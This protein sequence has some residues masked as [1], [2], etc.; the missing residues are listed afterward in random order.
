MPDVPDHVKHRRDDRAAGGLA[1]SSAVKV[2]RKLAAEHRAAIV[3]A[4]GRL[5]REQGF[6]GAGVAAITRAAGLTHG[7]FYGH[8]ASKSALATEACGAAFVESLA[9]LE[10]DLGRY[11]EAYLSERHRDRCADGCPMAAHASEVGRQGGA[12]QAEFAGGVGRFVDALAALLP[13]AAGDP[14]E[15]SRRA[16][17]IVAALVG[18]MALARATAAAAPGLSLEIL[19]SLRAELPGLAGLDR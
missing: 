6:A 12:L 4:A 5:F 18:G 3:S 1:E 13:A 14:C 17:A 16:L 10:G 19:A 15:R 8:F 2:T 9:R 7:G 11:F